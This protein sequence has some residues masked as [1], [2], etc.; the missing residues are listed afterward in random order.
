MGLVV[1]AFAVAV[2]LVIVPR[3]LEERGVAAAEISTPLPTATSTPAAVAT[4][5]APATSATPTPTPTVR[6]P[7][8]LVVEPAQLGLPASAAVAVLDVTDGDRVVAGGA[9]AFDTASIVKVNIL[10]ALLL[11]TDG[12]LTASQ[13][14]LASNM[15]TTSSNE[16]ASS[17][18]AAVGSRTGLTQLNTRLGLTSTVVGKSGNWGLTQ[19]TVVDQLRLLQVVFTDDS[20]LSADS[21]AYVVSLMTKVEADQR[22]G[23]PAADTHPATAA[24]KN[25]WLQRSTSGLWDINSIGRVETGGH[26]YLVASLSES[27]KTMDAGVA[28]VEKATRAGIDAITVS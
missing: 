19:T 20:P 26:T 4:P 27:N 16:A 7:A 11:K 28:L 9:T 21:R 14:S 18:F 5:S 12:K 22:W 2:S 6:V 13:K 8:N 17:L 1:L 3:F 24:V 23:T 10:V 25:G 15:I